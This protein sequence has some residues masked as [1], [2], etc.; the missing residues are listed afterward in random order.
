MKAE[1]S[2]SSPDPDPSHLQVKGNLCCLQKPLR[3]L[4]SYLGSSYHGAAER[5]SAA[6]LT[7]TQLDGL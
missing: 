5:L 3:S 7:G 1:T 2:A 6:E 4:G